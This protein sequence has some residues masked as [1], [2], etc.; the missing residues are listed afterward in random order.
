MTIDR[1]ALTPQQRLA[2]SRRALFN[3]LG[4]EHDDRQPSVENLAE[5]RA[6]SSRPDGVRQ[7]SDRLLAGFPMLAV[8]RNI[9][10]RWWRRHPANAVVQLGRPILARYAK[11]QPVKLMAYAAGTGALL[12]ILRPWRLLSVTALAAAVF[13]TS[14][15]ADMV[16]TLMQNNDSAEK[17]HD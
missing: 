8:A 1:S 3:E 4:Y 10:E 6:L 13:K 7:R 14:D 16:T 12:M 5:D 9:G 17:L 15:I 11:K 2:I